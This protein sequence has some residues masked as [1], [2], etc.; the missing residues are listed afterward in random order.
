MTAAHPSPF[1]GAWYPGDAAEL[2]ALLADR[3]AES[4]RRT[5]D[6]LLPDALAYVVP[7]AGPAYSGTVAAAAYRSLAQ[8][9]PERV[10]VLAFPHRGGLRGVAAPDVDR[11]A[12]PFGEVPL[13]HDF[14]GVPRLPEAEL[15]DHSFEIQLP[16]LQKATPESRITA[17]YVGHMNS[18]ARQ[19]MAAR[20]AEAWRPGTVFL[21]SSDFTHYGYSFG[22]LPFPNDRDIADH[23]RELDFDCIGAAGS[24]DSTLFLD[25]IARRRA[26]ACGTAPIA[27]LDDIL[28]AR[29]TDGVYPSVL[30]YQTSGEICGDYSHSVSYAALGYY[31]RTAFELGEADRAALLHAAEATLAELRRTGERHPVEAI[32]SPALGHTRRVR[33]LASGR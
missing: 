31:P 8:Q 5:G 6:Y 1:S 26:N 25:T 10:V 17:L 9:R 15:C 13:D 21:A 19:Q 33:H 14:I 3:F 7:H 16:F 4:E 29:G 22:H 28:R 20:L 2:A 18:T 27:L 23:L 11:V 30:D 24:L 32:G 12:T